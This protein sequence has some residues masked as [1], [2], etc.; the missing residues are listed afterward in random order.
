MWA[1]A[2]QRITACCASSGARRTA[3]QLLEARIVYGRNIHSQIIPP[4]HRRDVD[5][6]LQDRP[7]DLPEHRPAAIGM[8]PAA[9]VGGTSALDERVMVEIEQRAFQSLRRSG[10]HTS[11][12]CRRG[13]SRLP[14]GGALA[15][16]AAGLAVEHQHP[17]GD[18]GDNLERI[19][20]AVTVWAARSCWADLCPGRCAARSDALLSPGPTS[21]CRMGAAAAAHRYRCRPCDRAKLLRYSITV[22]RPRR[23]LAQRR[24]GRADHDARAGSRH[25]MNSVTSW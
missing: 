3:K 24:L 9:H 10:Y 4:D 5:A 16:H 12:S 15:D 13:R 7:R 21:D 19:F 2:Q 25:R 20:A 23:L 18:P 6:P 17:A 1:P 11:P 8:E 14:L 22:F